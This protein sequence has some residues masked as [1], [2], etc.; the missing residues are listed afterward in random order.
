MTDTLIGNAG[1]S[2]LFARDDS[3]KLKPCEK[4]NR[5]IHIGSMVIMKV[6]TSLLPKDDSNV[7]KWTLLKY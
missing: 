7:V 6:H 5:N 3:V 4:S 1:V 2:I